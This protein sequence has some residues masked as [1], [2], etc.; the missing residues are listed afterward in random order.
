[1]SAVGSRVAELPELVPAR[2]LNEYAYCPR[3]FFLEWVDSLWASNADVA[4]GDRRHRRVDAA[5]GAAPLPDDGE[6][7]AARS[8]ELSSERLGIVAK[9]DLLEGAGGVV[10]PVDT[11][12][13]H[14][15]ADG[16]ALGGRRDPG[17]RAGAVAARARVHV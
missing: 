4:E 17:L 8:V 9:L 12:K 7:K 14:P 16:H 11:K 3:L 13:G 1:M 5:G 10:T 6:L 2:M 15:A